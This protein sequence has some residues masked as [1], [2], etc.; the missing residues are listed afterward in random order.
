[1]K[2]VQWNVSREA[3]PMS[4]V[5]RY[6]DELFSHIKRLC[7][8][9]L[10]ERVPRRRGKYRGN[11]PVSWLLRPSSKGADI[12]HA[13]FQTFAPVALFRKPR[14]FI[15]TVQD[16]IP[17]LY[18]S[19]VRD[20]STRL[21]WIFTPDALKKVD[22]IIAISEF[23]KKEIIRILG[24]SPDKITVVYDGVDHSAYHPMSKEE[25]KRKFKLTPSEKHILVVASN[26]QHKRMDLVVKVFE[27]IKKQRQGIKLVKIGYGQMLQGEGIISPGW[28][29]ESDMPVLFN[30]AD[31]FL[32]TAEYEGFGL[33]VL[34]ALACGTPVVVSNRASIPEIVGDCGE[35]INLNSENCV[36]DFA[37][38]VL[39]NIDKDRD[40]KAVERSN[41]FQ[42]ENTARD[43]FNVYQKILGQS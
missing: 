8:D 4:G 24:I 18:P 29:E 32:H 12:V 17:M 36:Q 21:Q 7:P 42:W 19:T 30:S 34:E 39:N 33:P 43:T 10:L 20:I 40:L 37:Q 25:S 15:V 28:V 9:W 35:M 3:D 16:L 31:V 26:E 38:A 11:I 2:I 23:V 14:K 1:M 41:L 13:T 5:K 22:H 27:E 6:E